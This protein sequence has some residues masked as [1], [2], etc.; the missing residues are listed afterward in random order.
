M[1]HIQTILLIIVLSLFMRTQV[2]AFDHEISDASA[3]ANASVVSQDARILHLT[4]YLEAKNSPLSDYAAVFV[5]EADRLN[6]NW[7]LVAAIAGVESTFGKHIP[8]NS[9]NAWGWGVFTGQQ[10]GI[11]FTGWDDGIRTVSEGL[12]YNYIDKGRTTVDQIGRIYAASGTWS[13]KVKWMLSDIESF[14]PNT[15]QALEVTI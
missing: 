3:Q 14:S 4:K 13:Q 7:K 5:G 8:T 9:Y 12:K 15:P 10:D 2:Y 1:K 6:I 11:H